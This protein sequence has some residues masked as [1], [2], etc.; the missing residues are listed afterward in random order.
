MLRTCCICHRNATS[1]P[2]HPLCD[3][4]G[5]PWPETKRAGHAVCFALGLL[6]GGVMV[7]LLMMQVGG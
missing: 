4:C 6:L 3:E 2:K 1:N 5:P 7:G